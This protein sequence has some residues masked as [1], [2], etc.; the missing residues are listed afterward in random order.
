MTRPSRRKQKPSSP[1]PTPIRPATSGDGF[2]T[3]VRRRLRSISFFQAIFFTYVIVGLIVMAFVIP[4]FQKSDEPAHYFRVVSLANLDLTCTKEPDGEYYMYMKRRYADFPVTIHVWDVALM[5][6]VRYDRDWLRADW[7]RPEFDE[8]VRVPDICNLPPVGYLPNV[9][10]VWLGMPFENPLVGFHIGRVLGAVFFVVCLAFAIRLTPERYRLP[11]YF[12]GGLPIVLHQVSAFSYDTTQ[13][14][15]FP[16]LFAYVAKFAVEDKRIERR[17]LLWF[18]GILLVSVSIRSLSYIPLLALFFAIRPSRIG[19]SIR[20]Y[21]TVSGI[22][23][24]VTALVTLILSLVYLPRVGA[25]PE[26]E[27]EISAQR[28]LDHV[29]GDPWGFVQ[30]CYL[31]FRNQGEW[32]LL[33]SMGVFGWID[34][35]MSYFPYYL[36]VFVFGLAFYHV[37]KSDESLVL[38]RKQI[39]ALFL[40]IVGTAALLFLSL[41]L[42]WTPVEGKEVLGLQGRYFIGLLPFVM[43]AMSQLALSIGKQRFMNA[44]ILIFICIVL[45]N[46]YRAVDLRY[47]G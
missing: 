10:G 13:L 4:P 29:L 43:F 39:G 2:G 20:G 28:Q 16:L 3:A 47:Y 33:Q 24:G 26:A 27:G 21:L 30:A 31:T 38:N 18:L 34:T 37:F 36:G 42:V 32:L 1:P 14:A 11:V 25:V 44:M 5:G 17:H 7:S 9:V 35:P 22:F 41:Y 19:P 45:Y 15:L 6:D 46:M 23:F 40:T 12:F 8:D